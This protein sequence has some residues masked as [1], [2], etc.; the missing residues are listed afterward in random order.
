[1]LSC[2]GISRLV[3]CQ[4]SRNNIHSLL[5]CFMSEKYKWLLFSFSTKFI[6]TTINIYFLCLF[7]VILA[8]YGLDGTVTGQCL[9]PSEATT[10]LL[11]DWS[12]FYP[13]DKTNSLTDSNVVEV[14]VN[15]VRMPYPS[16]YVLVTDMD[17][18]EN[19][20]VLYGMPSTPPN[21]RITTSVVPTTSNLTGDKKE[22]QQLRAGGA[23][24]PTNI[25][26]LTP[27]PSPV[28]INSR[29]PQQGPHT[30]CTF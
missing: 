16:C 28:Q 21:E 23:I 17:D 4:L 7:A 30:V 20:S 25:Q 12:Q 11:D 26:Q 14:I 18:N 29:V 5:L 1:M 2:K 8:P 27:P 9:K 10:R 22:H 15:G 24:S 13:L 3:I 19:S 6:C